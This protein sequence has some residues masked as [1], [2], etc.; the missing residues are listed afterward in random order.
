MKS[1]YH[2][3][4]LV[5]S[6]LV[7]GSMFATPAFAQETSPS[8]E[9]SIESEAIV[10]TGSRI[11]R[12]DL[13]T[14]SPVSVISGEEI[15]LRQ[16][17]SAEELIRELPSVRPSLGAGV[18][19]GGN[20]SATVDLR[21]LGNNR[22]L[23][24]LDGR[25]VTPFGLDGVVNLNVIPVG[26]VERVDVVTGGASSVYGADAVAG[27]VNFIT[28]RDFSGVS[29]SSNY[30][31]SEQGDATQTRTDLLLGT[32]LGDGRGNVV[33]G[34]S[35]SKRDA[36]K[37]VDREFSAVPISSTTG[38]AST[39][40][41]TVPSLFRS[42]LAS[43]SNPNG[44]PTNGYGA[45]F[46]PD[47]GSFR[48]ATAEDVATTNEGNYLLT[49]LK[50]I[51]AYA[52]GHYEVVDGIEIYASAMF[53]KNETRL[54]LNSTGTFSNSYALSLNNPYLPD[55][56]RA[57][58]CAANRIST[59][60]CDAAAAAV[61]GPG[62]AGYRQIT[63]TPSRRFSE[64]G[65]R[66]NTNDSTL[67]QLQ[68]GVRG[69][70]S[71]TIKFDV[72]AQYGETS[73]NQLRENWGSNSRV[74]QALLAYTDASGNAVCQD[75]SNGCVPLNLF[76][77]LGSI[78]PEMLEFVGLDSMVRRLVKLT[79]VTG[80]ISGD[81]FGVTSPLASNPV[82]FAIGAEYR[83][84]SARAT[85]DAAAQIQG[86]VLGTGA[87]TPPDYGSYDV[88]EVFGELV[89]P[90]IEDR[91]VKSATVEA[92][93]RYSDYSTTGSNVTWKVGGS[94]EPVTGFKT[95][96][97]Y[98]V[99]V[100]SPNIQE[101]YQSPV[102]AI[103]S[104][105]VDPC[106]GVTPSAPETL[107]LATGA[108]ADS[109]GAI[110][111]PSS[112]QITL[113]TQGNPNLDVETAKTWTVGA[114]FTPVFLPGFS[115][116]VDWFRIRIDDLI[117]A[118]TQSD[119]I[120]GCYST[121]LNP[122]QTPNAF[123][124]LIERDPVTGSLYTGVNAAGVILSSSNLG[125]M[126][127]GGIDWSMRYGLDLANILPGNP[128]RF[129]LNMSGTWLDHFWTQATPN[130]ITREC[131]GRYSTGCTNARPKWK[132]NVRGTYE[133]G[134]FS[135]SLLWTHLSGVNYEPIG[136]AAGEVA[137]TTPQA[138]STASTYNALYADFRRIDAYDYFDLNL[139]FDVSE[140]MSFSL[141]VE[142]LFDKQPPLLGSGVAG[143]AF[144][145][146]NTMPTTYDP[147]GRS[148]TVSARLT[149]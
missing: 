102:R 107:C 132:W 104:L 126:G 98:Q 127:T 112:G 5:A 136:P 96:A 61:G 52:A 15:T 87:R 60:D 54:A 105:T 18:N 115:A 19:N 86:E 140:N 14:S 128:G 94:I 81:L 43:A 26:L 36:L 142:N 101:L 114:V 111:Q 38:Q 109:Y 119:I 117:S 42:S 77:D 27:V 129:T 71:S 147:I 46:D 139:G 20:G 110:S 84:T 12:A 88:K 85:P 41:L 149:F 24:I 73:Q 44:L 63:V 69:N 49:P 3:R 83:D 123:C 146:G 29:L 148:Y 64:Y 9:S 143:T 138:G 28:K 108:P 134:P 30:R 48:A 21:G 47:T 78:T 6:L 37:A 135:V 75:T 59:T 55:T 144:N 122:S 56:A 125:R 7:S 39:S 141:L 58:L 34:L 103:G 11:V 65:Y 8:A 57:Q 97:M 31:I 32:N 79:M 100:R 113:S 25:R 92:G 72:T 10:V 106:G 70:I 13:E 33:L 121:S 4:S 17:N 16:P 95:R 53:S 51:N 22:T 133:T 76:G 2:S 82:A 118:P 45:I 1:F 130:T 116:T 40:T 124:E 62:T 91:L 50:S 137:L 99:A 23:V 74:A 145:N 90:L 89:V 68:G 93:I 66:Y 120:N 80:S 67:F 35:Y 131:A